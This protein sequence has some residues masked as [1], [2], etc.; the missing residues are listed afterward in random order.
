MGRR[1]ASR[2]LSLSTPRGLTFSFPTFLKPTS[3][4]GG[5]GCRRGG[6]RPRRLKKEDVFDEAEDD[7]EGGAESESR[8]AGCEND[9]EANS[10]VENHDAGSISQNDAVVSEFYGRFRR[11]GSDRRRFES[12]AIGKGRI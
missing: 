3:A 5:A 2:S 11:K 10:A 4:I 7:A 9:A 12:G 6:L 8:D 1:L